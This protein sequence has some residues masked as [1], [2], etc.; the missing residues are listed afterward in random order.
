VTTAEHDRQRFLDLIA[1]AERLGHELEPLVDAAE[2]PV[3]RQGVAA[4]LRDLAR[5]RERV[6]DGTYRSWPRGAGLGISRPFSELW[7]WPAEIEPLVDSFADALVAVETF[8]G[9]HQE[10]LVGG[11]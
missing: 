1:E 10:T 11:A 2:Q 4:A 6:L 3:H 5:A 8:W 7:Q 9:T